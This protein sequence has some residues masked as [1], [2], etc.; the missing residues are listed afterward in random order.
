MSRLFAAALGLAAAWPLLASAQ[1]PQPVQAPAAAPAMGDSAKGLIGSWEFS[2]ADRDKRCTAT[3][4]AKRTK[5]GSEVTFSEGCN[6]LFPL[7]DDVAGWTFPDND[8]LRL[9]DGDGRA[10]IEFSEVE[11]GVYEAPTPG[12]GVL[13]LQNAASAAGTPAKLPDQLAGGW[14]I[15]RGDKAVCSVNLSMEPV[16]EALALTLKPGCDQ[17]IARLA[18]T[19]GRLDRGVLIFRAPRGAPWRFEEI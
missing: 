16:M 13:F 18:F 8:L 5:A 3:F 2:N 17:A 9:V 7:I 19:H 4:T 6:T 10:L 1:A 11:D 15:R 14:T 12:L